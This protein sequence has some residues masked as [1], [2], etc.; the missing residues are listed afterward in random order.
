M[1]KKR[2]NSLT[3]PSTLRLS[4]LPKKKDPFAEANYGEEA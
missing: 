4:H 1:M 2:T 3:A